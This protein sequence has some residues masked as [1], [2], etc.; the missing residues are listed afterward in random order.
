[1]EHSDHHHHHQ[2]TSGSDPGRIFK[3]G[4]LLNLLF[5]GIEIYFGIT[6]NSLALVSDGVHNLTDVFGLTFAWVGF[7]FSK[8]AATKK[9]SIYAAFTNTS[10]IL[11]TSI[12]ITVEAFKRYHAN[13]T[14]VAI[15]M[16]SVAFV[17]LLINFFTANLFHKDHHHDLNMKSAY[18]HLMTDAAVSLGVVFTGIII[19]YTGITWIDPLIS[20]IISVIIIF[21]TWSYFREAFNMVRGKRP[22]SITDQAV[23][24]SVMKQKEISDVTHIQVWSLSTSENALKAQIHVEEELNSEQINHIKHR[25]FHDFKM[26]EVSFK[27]IRE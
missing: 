22:A 3:I 27:Q 24:T 23:R 6:G 13:E 4:I 9:L 21:T 7:L 10:L 26:T 17:G 8:R 2:H 1:M 25:L 5:V 12:W 14:P 19:F 16:I 18:L 15:T 20:G 11:L